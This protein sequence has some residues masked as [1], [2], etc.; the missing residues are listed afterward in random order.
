MPKIEWGSPG[1]KTF[2]FGVDQGVI[3]MNDGRYA[4][5]N[6]LVSVTEKSGRSSEPVYFDGHKVHDF[7]SSDSYAATIKAITFPDEIL[8]VEGYG[9]ILDGIWVG[10]QRPTTFCM[11]YR[12][13]IAND[14]EPDQFAYRIHILYNVSLVASDK[15]Y[16]TVGA[17]ASPMTFE[18]SATTVPEESDWTG[19][20]AH[21]FIDSHKVTPAVLEWI[22]LKLYGGET[23]NPAFPTYSDLLDYIYSYYTVEIVD[24]N[25][26][27]W[28]ANTELPGIIVMTSATQ[29]QIIGVDSTTIDA[30]SFTVSSTR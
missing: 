23:A 7:I 2:Q 1:S 21:I 24:N 14:I 22:E 20:G 9:R 30:N 13:Q 8:E 19:P 18:W 3:Y 29:F 25:D 6:G 28:T 5:W 26:G 16:N 15:V 11:T 12:T 10:E 17:L 4:P 27:T